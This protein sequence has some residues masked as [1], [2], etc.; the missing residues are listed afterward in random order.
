M[1][2]PALKSRSRATGIA[3]AAAPTTK[4]AAAPAAAALSRPERPRCGRRR[5][6]HKDDGGQAEDRGAGTGQDRRQDRRRQADP[7]RQVAAA[8]GG[9][10]EH[11]G[12]QDADDALVRRVARGWPRGAGQPLRPGA[13]SPLP[14]RRR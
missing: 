14:R 6:Q 7:G 8:Q 4:S 9:Q 13:G 11:S 1:T 3:K 12:G 5:C 2:V 10:R